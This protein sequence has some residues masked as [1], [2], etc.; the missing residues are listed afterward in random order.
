MPLGKSA[1]HEAFT[2]ATGAEGIYPT[3]TPCASVVQN[4]AVE[5]E[6]PDAVRRSA[7]LPPAKTNSPEP[8]VNVV[9]PLDGG[10]D[11]GAAT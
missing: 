3:H 8:P 4:T 11:A 9:P 1:F 5:A 2:I 6:H 7:L 10:G